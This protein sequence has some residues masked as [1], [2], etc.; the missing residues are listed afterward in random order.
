VAIA[1]ALALRPRLMLA[2]EPTSGLDTRTAQR[3]LALFRG[4]AQSQGTTFIIVSHDPMV[5]EQVDTA[6]DMRDGKVGPHVPEHLPQAEP[7]PAQPV[8]VPQNEAEPTERPEGE[9]ARVET[10]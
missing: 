6:Y 3:I 8:S 1:R 5:A 2:D 9:M 4:I 7:D 10:V